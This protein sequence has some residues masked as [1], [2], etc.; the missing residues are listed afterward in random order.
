M[1]TGDNQDTANFIASQA[2]IDTVIAQ[3]LP[4]QKAD[5]IKQLKDQ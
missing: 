4:D 1:L 3:V 5:Y 2:G